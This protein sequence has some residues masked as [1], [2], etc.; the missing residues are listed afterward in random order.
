M[1]KVAAIYARK[2]TA[3]K[4]VTDE[5]KSVTRQVEQA[6]AFAQAMGWRTDDRYV[7][8]DDG[9]SGTEFERRPGLQALLAMLKPK[10]PFHKLIVSEQKSLGREMVE[11]MHLIKRFTQRG[12]E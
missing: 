3:Q 6:R 2:S 4:G 5:Q 8:V 1:K 7:F 12:V 11:T 9:V 10:P